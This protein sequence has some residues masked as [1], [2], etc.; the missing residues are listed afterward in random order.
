MN[1]N[2][3]KT[4]MVVETCNGR[5][6]LVMRGGFTYDRIVG[7]G[8]DLSEQYWSVLDNL[9]SD[10]RDGEG[11]YSIIRVFGNICNSFGARISDQDRTCLWER[12]AEEMIEIDGTKWSKSTIK[13]ALHKHA[14]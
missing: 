6:G 13:E 8:Y 9:P 3:L 10:L 4:G 11:E 5:F 14:G 7:N 2:D 1:K 12:P